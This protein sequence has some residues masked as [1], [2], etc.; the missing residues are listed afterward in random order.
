MSNV[1]RHIIRGI[2]GTL[3]I[4][5]N[6]LL[7][8]LLLMSGFGGMVPPS[9][10]PYF[11]MLAMLFPVILTVS[12]IALIINL[13]WFRRLAVINILSL[14]LCINPILTFCPMNV[15]RPSVEE[16]EQSGKKT[17]KLMTFNVFGFVYFNK[18]DEKYNSVNATVE[19]ILDQDPDMVVCQEA[20]DVSWNAFIYL[21]NDE[22]RNRLHERYPYRTVTGRGMALYSKY[23]FEAIPTRV[24]DKYQLD[25]CR[26]DIDIMGDTVHLFNIHMQSIGLTSEDKELYVQLTEGEASDEIEEI[27]HN[28]IS[29]LKSAF[30]ARAAQ[31]ENV[32]EILDSVSGNIILCGDFNDIQGCYAARTIQGSDMTDAYR[33]AG[34]G[35]AIT[36]HADRLY[37]RIDHIFYE[38]H[39]KALRAWNGRCPLSDHYPLMAIMELTDEPKSDKPTDI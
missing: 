16:I 12:V 1:S 24:R 19:Y 13:I 28:I 25:L 5:A 20:V 38:G 2:A 10:T 18:P 30:R 29:K 33:E 35:P 4:V 23:P 26:Y 39:L 7:A 9:V 17:F 37:F 21:C 31:A 36:Y 27:R 14:L 32:R 8:T 22:Q 34:L 11:A 15:F 6:A 3:G